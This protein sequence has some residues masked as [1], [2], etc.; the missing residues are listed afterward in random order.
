MI[1][2]YYQDEWVTIYH[3]DNRDIV[4]QL[5]RFNFLLT[6]PPYGI[7]QAGIKNRNSR[8]RPILG[9]GGGAIVPQ[10]NYG[11]KDW[12]ESA[13]TI[14][15]LE[16]HIKLC[17]AAVIFGG[18]YLPLPPSPKWLIWDKEN[19]NTDFADCELAWTNLPGA[20]RMIKHRWSGMLQHDMANKEI[21][22][23]PTQKPLRVMKW[24][25]AQA[26]IKPPGV[27]YDPY[28]GSGT[29]LLAALDLGFKSVGIDQDEEYCEMAVKRIKAAQAQQKLF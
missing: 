5:G 27:I 29:S 20:T 15:Q 22:V 7:N 19:G 23:H 12:D 26:K 1:E 8:S 24:C 6:D 4:G 18:N 17:S 21:R 16:N 3:G 11:L 28:M 10:G 2:P 13:P 14:D 9:K 25:L